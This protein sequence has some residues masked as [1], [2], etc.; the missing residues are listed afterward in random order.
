MI[1]GNPRRSVLHVFHQSVKV[2]PRGRNTD[3]TDGGAIPQLSAIQLGD[4]DV[5]T[6]PKVILQTA[7]DLP[8]VLDRLCCFDVEFE[9]EKRD[10]HSVVGR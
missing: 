4:R 9:R 7:D 8:A 2:I 10:G 3:D 6:G 5:E 1:V